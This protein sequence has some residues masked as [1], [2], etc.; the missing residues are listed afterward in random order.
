MASATCFMGSG[1]YDVIHIRSEQKDH[2]TKKRL[3]LPWTYQL[4]KEREEPLGI[5][6]VDDVLT[7]GSSVITSLETLGDKV[8]DCKKIIILVDREEGGRQAI[9]NKYKIPITSIFTKSDFI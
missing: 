2:G 3:E 7:T 5:A 1:L 8:A 6:L 4:S 9:E